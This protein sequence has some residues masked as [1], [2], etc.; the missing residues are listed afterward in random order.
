[1][2]SDTTFVTN[3]V[4]DLCAEVP[5][6]DPTLTSSYASSYVRGM[7]SGQDGTPATN[8]KSALTT[9]AV[10]KHFKA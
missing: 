10:C 3:F 5:G 4:T 7:Q 8:G 9:V 2:G 6:E 1:M